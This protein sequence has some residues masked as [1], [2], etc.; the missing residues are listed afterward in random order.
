MG[1]LRGTN[2]S[3]FFGQMSQKEKKRGKV[4]KNFTIIRNVG[5]FTTRRK[6]VKNQQGI[7]IAPPPTTQPISKYAPGEQS[8]QQKNSQQISD[9]EELRGLTVMYLQ[10]RKE[11]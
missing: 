6:V 1:V 10:Q 3:D 2:L 9:E 7:A 5:I 11:K 4:G 8:R